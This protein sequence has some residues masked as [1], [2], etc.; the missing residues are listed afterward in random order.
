M[1]KPNDDRNGDQKEII[2]TIWVK[3]MWQK[4]TFYPEFRGKKC[5]TGL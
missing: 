4:A 5:S 3:N 1:T 2:K